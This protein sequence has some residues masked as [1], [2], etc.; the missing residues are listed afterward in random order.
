MI[1]FYSPY[2]TP[3]VVSCRI[4]VVAIENISNRIA[5]NIAV[6]ITLEALEE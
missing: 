3:I 1:I 2:W 5:T 6:S 4:A